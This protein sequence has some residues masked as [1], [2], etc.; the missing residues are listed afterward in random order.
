MEQLFKILSDTIAT[1][2][3]VVPGLFYHYATKGETK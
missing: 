3:A 2:M 1:L